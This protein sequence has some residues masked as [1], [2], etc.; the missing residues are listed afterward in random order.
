MKRRSVRIALSVAV[1]AV[2]LGLAIRGV[3][4]R[5]TL[6]AIQGANYRFVVPIAAVSIWTL[7]IRAQRWR[8]FLEPLGVPPM[9]ALVSA[10]NIGFMANMLLPLRIGEV[11]RPVL[12]SRRQNLPLGGIL[13]TVL[14]ERIFD[15]FTVLLLF[16]VSML[17]GRMS[18]VA[19]GWGVMLMGLAGVVGAIIIVLRWQEARAL[20]AVRRLAGP[21]PRVIGDPFC[22]FMESFVRALDI[23]Q[24][25]AAFGRAFGWSLF[26]WLI[27]AVT[28]GLALAMFHFPL[29]S[30]LFVTAIIAIAVSVPS[31][32]GY[33]G[34]F[35]LG[36]KVALAMYGIDESDA[37]AFSLVHHVVQFVAIVGAG[38]YSLW[39]EGLSLRDVEAVEAEQ[40]ATA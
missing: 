2:F 18:D 9:Q 21:L 5:A 8:V 37:I 34:S 27:I 14:L 25:P 24:S 33:I 13:A 19:R 39:R 7:Y 29:R 30:F 17:A 3:N 12:L 20:R 28:N 38:V 35:Q 32:P 15:M 31:A 36:C 16:G 23:V 26:L 22:H 4:W 11:V 1:S 10:T 40:R 6:Q